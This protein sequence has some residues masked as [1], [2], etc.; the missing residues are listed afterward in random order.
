[1]M[2]RGTKTYARASV[3][4]GTLHTIRAAAESGHFDNLIPQEE[5]E[6][7]SQ[8]FPWSRDQKQKVIGSLR[9]LAEIGLEQA[10]IPPIEVPV[11]YIAG[12]VSVLFIP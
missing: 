11:E 1:M 3:V 4:L 12:M 6:M 8:A 7:V 10:A 2:S 5:Y 9:S